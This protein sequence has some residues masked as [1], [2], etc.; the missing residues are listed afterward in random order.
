MLKY[1]ILKFALLSQYEVSEILTRAVWR[2][3]VR[4][5][6]YSRVRGPTSQ[7][8]WCWSSWYNY[9]D[10]KFKKMNLIII[11]GNLFFLASGPQQ[12]Y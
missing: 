12:T 1:Q 6:K 9:Y 8:I 11:Y 7:Q 2:W 3:R 4:R 10:N 5:V